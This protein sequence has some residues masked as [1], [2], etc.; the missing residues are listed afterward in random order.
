MA[1][2]ISEE[3]FRLLI[4]VCLVVLIII[5]AVIAGK[6]KSGFSNEQFEDA[7][8]TSMRD[9]LFTHTGADQKSLQSKVDAAAAKAVKSQLTG[10]RDAPV[11]FQDYDYDMQRKKGG[12][13]GNT[14]EGFESGAISGD[15]LL[16]ALRSG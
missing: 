2:V 5:Q 15:K 14:R 16:D 7:A 8:N 6:T 9:I 12:A 13:V 1:G 3:L 10:F 11:F 4:V